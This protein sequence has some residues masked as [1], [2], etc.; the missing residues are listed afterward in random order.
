[1]LYVHRQFTN[2]NPAKLSFIKIF[3]NLVL[4]FN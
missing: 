1:M 2:A 4:N 3:K